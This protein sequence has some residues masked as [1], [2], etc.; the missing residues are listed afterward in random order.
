MDLRFRRVARCNW[1]KINSSKNRF[2]KIER[3]SPKICS[4]STFRRQTP[5]S[6]L[7]NGVCFPIFDIPICPFPRM[8]THASVS[9]DHTKQKPNTHQSTVNHHNSNVRRRLRYLGRSEQ[10]SGYLTVLVSQTERFCPWHSGPLQT[11]SMQTIKVEKCF[12][13]TYDRY[14]AGEIPFP[15]FNSDVAYG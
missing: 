4:E 3:Q 12:N 11:T 7:A 10:A 9:Q 5:L 13:R 8:F 1:R 15:L 6:I 2:S 14:L